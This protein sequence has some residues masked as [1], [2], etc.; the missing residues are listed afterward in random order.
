M[1]ALLV[2]VSLLIFNKNIY[3]YKEN[4]VIHRYNLNKIKE[5]KSNNEIGKLVLKK[6]PND[7]YRY[8]MIYESELH[9]SYFKKYYDIPQDTSI[10]FE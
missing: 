5:Y 8:I 3:G 10:I 1:C 2:I 7:K 9:E 6:L 4:S